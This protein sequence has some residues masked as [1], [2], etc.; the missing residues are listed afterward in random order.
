MTPWIEKV[1]LGEMVARTVVVEGAMPLEKVLKSE[2]DLLLPV[3]EP[4]LFPLDLYT[5]KVRL[6]RWEGGSG[7]VLSGIRDFVSVLENLEEPACWVMI[8]GETTSYV[9][10]ISADWSKVLA[11][12]AIDSPGEAVM[13]GEGPEVW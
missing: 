1:A 6:S 11:S 3:S 8:T 2:P 4:S 9:L 7:P 10:L 5:Y 12:M 13:T